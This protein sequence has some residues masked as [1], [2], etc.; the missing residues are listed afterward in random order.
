MCIFEYRLW[1]CHS[2]EC[3]LEEQRCDKLHDCDDLSDE[4]HCGKFENG[5]EMKLVSFHVC[6]CFEWL[7]VFDKFCV[8]VTNTVL[9]CK[10]GADRKD[11]IDFCKLKPINQLKMKVRSA[12]PAIDRSVKR[13][14]ASQWSFNRTV[15]C[16]LQNLSQV[17]L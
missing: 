10:N 17:I 9:M 15:P 12:I 3:I 11:I 13:A 6:V 14:I 4:I 16:A 1:S 7:T 5:F 2:G 8:S